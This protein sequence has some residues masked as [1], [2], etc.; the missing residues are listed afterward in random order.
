MLLKLISATFIFCSVSFCNLQ[1]QSLS[2]ILAKAKSAISSITGSS[3]DKITGTWIYESADIKFTSDNL[4]AQAGGKLA[5]SKIESQINSILEKQGIAPNDLTL[6]FSDDSTYTCTF[7]KDSQKTAKGTYLFKDDQLTFTP[8]LSKKAITT[9]ANLG[10]S[11]EIT[12]N[13]DK[14]LTL[15]QGLSTLQTNSSAISTIATMAKNYS[16]MQIGLKF[17]KK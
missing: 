6:T 17:K 14:I 3:T 15:V 1:A 10:S 13:A 2:D 4:L 5:S 11:L 16:G 7:K 9:T 12:C 8:A